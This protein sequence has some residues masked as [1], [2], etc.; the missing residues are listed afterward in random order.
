MT[1]NLALIEALRA[2]GGRAVYLGRDHAPGAESVERTLVDAVGGVPFLALPSE[3]LRRY[4]DWRNFTMP[5]TVL[6]GLWRAYRHIRAA[7]PEALFSK[8]GFVA[9][10]AVVGAWLNGV[11]VVL[12]ESDGSLGLAHRLSLPF[13]RAVCVAQARARGGVRHKRVVHTGAPIRAAFLSARPEEARARFSLTGARPLLVVFGG[14]LGSAHLNA[15][16]REALEA[17]LARYEV[18]HVCGGGAV[19]A[20][21]AAAHE[22]R[23]YRQAEYVRE[24]FAD[25]LAAARLVVGRAGANTLAELLLLRRP[26]LLVPLPTASSRGDQLLNAEEHARAGFGL[27]LRDEELTAEEL[28][29]AL[30]RLE[31]GYA[32]F[33]QA[34][35]RSPHANGAEATL[36]ELARALR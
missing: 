34:M 7:R 11:P 2:R 6:R 10:P 23:G 20:D 5:F 8:G 28:L 25:L 35:A 27:L 29:S 31:E 13:A 36:E 21:L 18:F 12:H 9:L 15:V 19:R 1:P 30:E 16:T 33:E 4:F 24:G 17:L 3:R 26:A 14:S 32:G 22:E